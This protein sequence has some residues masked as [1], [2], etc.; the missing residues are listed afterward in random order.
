MRTAGIARRARHRRR[1][2]QQRSRHVRGD[3]AGGLPAQAGDPRSAGHPGAGRARAWRPSTGPARSGMEKTHR[4]ARARQA[5]RPDRRLDVVGAAD[6][7]VRSAVAPGLRHARRRRADDDRQRQGADAGPQDADARRA[8]RAGRGAH[9]AVREAVKVRAGRQARK[10]TEAMATYDRR[11]L[12]LRSRRST[13]AHPARSAGARS[14]ATTRPARRSTSSRVLKGGFVFMADLVR[15][16]S[17]RVTMDFIAVSSYGKGTKSSGEVRMLKD[18]DTSLEGRHVI[19]V[20]D[21]VD[22][23]LTLT[24][25]AGHPAGARAED[26]E[27]GVPAEQA[28]AAQG[29]GRGRV[30]RLHD[31]GSSSSSAT[32]ST[33]PR[34]TAT[35]RTSRSRCME[36]RVT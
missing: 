20:E 26:A 36:A 12:H 33:T 25:P 27:D 8:R 21:I 6:A 10:G 31:R 11:C 29:R 2:Q 34:S 9:G 35:C 28:V 1:G 13:A 5:R 15:A 24:L 23:G 30:H 22:T 16:M 32:G 3:A 14:S 4:L 18:L 7:D 19:I 17:P